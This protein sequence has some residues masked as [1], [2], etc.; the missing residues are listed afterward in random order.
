MS[1]S[2]KLTAAMFFTHRRDV[3]VGNL[4]HD[5]VIKFPIMHMGINYLIQR[6]D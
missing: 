1:L 2:V 5:K 6:S 4:I 3:N